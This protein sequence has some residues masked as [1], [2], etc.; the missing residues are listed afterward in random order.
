MLCIL[1]IYIGSCF[2][3][4]THF[5]R[6][7]SLIVINIIQLQVDYDSDKDKKKKKGKKETDSDASDEDEEDDDDDHPKKRGRPKGAGKEGIRGFSNAEIRRFVRSYKKFP[8][9]LKR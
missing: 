1:Y 5:S 7:N 2:K 9:P 4:K 8:A 3:L 6:F